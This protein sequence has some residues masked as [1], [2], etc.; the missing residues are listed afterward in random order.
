MGEEDYLFRAPVEELVRR[1]KALGLVTIKNAGH[2]CNID[3][4]E[5]YNQQTID[6]INKIE[7]SIGLSKTV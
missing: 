7:A 6:F 4:P 3:Q 5:A 1:D 2:V